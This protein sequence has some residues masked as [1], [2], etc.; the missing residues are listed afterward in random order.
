MPFP[1]GGGSSTSGSKGLGGCHLP[2]TEN[3]R[4]RGVAAAIPCIGTDALREEDSAS[5]ENIREGIDKLAA[6][7][8]PLGVPSNL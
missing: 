5:G 2:E 3:S 1:A 8:V 4:L 7:N 6:A